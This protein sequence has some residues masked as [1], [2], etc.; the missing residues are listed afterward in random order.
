MGRKQMGSHVYRF[1]YG[2]WKNVDEQFLGFAR[3]LRQELAITQPSRRG[4]RVTVVRRSEGSVASVGRTTPSMDIPRA[5][6]AAVQPI[7]RRARRLV[8]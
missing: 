3:R 2:S 1:S 7:Q 6:T 5:Q 8:S 4:P